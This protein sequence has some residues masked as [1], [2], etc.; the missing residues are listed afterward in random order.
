MRSS[1]KHICSKLFY[2]SLNFVVPASMS[3]IIVL[4]SS[5]MLKLRN[6]SLKSFLFFLFFFF[7]LGA[8]IY[9]LRSPAASQSLIEICHTTSFFW[10]GPSHPTVCADC[11]AMPPQD[12]T[13][14]GWGYLQLFGDLKFVIFTPETRSAKR[15]I[16]RQPQRSTRIPPVLKRGTMQSLRGYLIYRCRAMLIEINQ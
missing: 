14:E 6:L 1:H 3:N 8:H 5:F 15:V 12:N 16:R 7:I 10:S 2:T 13:G 4:L 11:T 9:V